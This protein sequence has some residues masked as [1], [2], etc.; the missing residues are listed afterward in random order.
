MYLSSS[1]VVSKV[2]N[3]IA[4]MKIKDR[5]NEAV[6]VTPVYQIRF[7]C[8]VVVNYFFYNEAVGFGTTVYRQPLQVPCLNGAEQIPTNMY[9][10]HTYFVSHS[11][12]TFLVLY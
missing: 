10:Y 2:S 8:F 4:I 3:E 7:C 1:S 6:G 11:Y 5:T 9:C 12:A